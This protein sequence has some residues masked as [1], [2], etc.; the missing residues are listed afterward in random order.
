MSVNGQSLVFPVVQ[1]IPDRLLA[2]LITKLNK[3]DAELTEARAKRETIAPEPVVL[4]ADLPALYRAHLDD[5]VDMLSDEDVSGRTSEDLHTL[6]DI[7]VVDCTRM[8][9]FTSLN[10]AASYWRCSIF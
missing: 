10:F 9:R 7:V 6:I 3:V 4:P 5:L 1:C 8:R 2:R